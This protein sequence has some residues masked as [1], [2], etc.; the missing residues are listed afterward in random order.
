MSVDRQLMRLFAARYRSGLVLV[1]VASV[2]LNVLVFAGSA[3]M[4]LVY[5]S[6]LPSR[7]VP[8][9]IGLFGMLVLVY[10]FQSVF[11][12]I[13]GEA[14]LGIANG[15]HDD[16]FEAVHYATVTRPLRGGADKGD[17]LQFTRDLDSIHTFLAGQGP[18]A[19]I[20]LPWVIMFMIVLFA[21][22]WWL[23]VTALAGVFVM[24][25]IAIVS[26]RRT[27]A[28][29]RELSN[30]TGRRSAAALSEIRFA[31]SAFAMG[32]QE[33]LVART[34]SW[35]TNFI[36]AQSY[37]SRTVSRLGGA[38]KAFRMLLQSLILSVGAML[39]IDGK[40]SGGVILASSVL[41]GRALAPVDQAIANW[42]GL[43]AARTGWSRIAQAVATFRKPAARGVLLDRPSS[44][45]SVRDIWVAPPGTQRFTLSGV[46]FT[47]TP[48]QVLAVV[49]PSAAGKTTLVR[50]I[51]GIWKPNRGEVR[52]DGATLDQWDP[53][54]LGSYFG[55]VPQTVDLVDGTIGQN[56]AR[57]DP[58]ATSEGI[59]A[60]ARAAGMHEVILAL[61]DGYETP[62][63]AGAVELSAGQRQR[64]GL[65]RAL[66]GDPFLLVLDEANSNLDTAG[67]AALANAIAGMRA[68]G[69]IVIMITHRPATLGP[70]T[71]L[72]VV[73][74]GRLVDFG[75]RD[76]VLQR[77]QAQSAQ[78]Q[79]PHAEGPEGSSNPAKEATA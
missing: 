10:A 30:I 13:R 67:D 2:M 68:R 38:S 51:L 4:L 49:G 45:L 27:S 70:A 59:I 66:Y 55:Y 17:G 23:G 3:Y 34:A 74:T 54:T 37:L 22:H 79:V 29:S 65:A 61:P 50:A 63:S 32:M 21:L 28:G 5:D 57:F 26:N 36:E 9:L 20:D 11:E 52:L 69:G 25:W 77:M 42:K 31:E 60:A 14:L 64:I 41:S 56:I 8:T 62:V 39:V 16:L 18:V 35:E 72:A 6:V 19:L 15:V 78:G 7:S 58:E 43:V 71:H 24:A 53:E 12:A 75:P 47:L 1:A 48:G 46:S 33:R 73:N 44:E 76:E 40:A